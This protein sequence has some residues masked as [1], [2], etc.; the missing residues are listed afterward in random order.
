VLIVALSGAAVNLTATRPLS[1]ANRENVAIQGG[2]QHA[3]TDQPTAV[4][5][6]H[7]RSEPQAVLIDRN[8]ALVFWIQRKLCADP[9]TI[10][11][12]EWWRSRVRQGLTKRERHP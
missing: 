5:T 7:E 8:V 1:R 2:F 11:S 3:L 9:C 12:G 10:R 4:I 6:L